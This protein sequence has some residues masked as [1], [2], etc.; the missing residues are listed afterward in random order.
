MAQCHKAALH[1]RKRHGFRAKLAELGAKAIEKVRCGDYSPFMST[2]PPE[3]I[4]VDT[5]RVSCDGASA[6][7][8]GDNYR[9]AALGH[10]R[11]YL[12]IDESGLVDCGYCDRRFV[13]KGGPA[14]QDG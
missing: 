6:I 8:G 7:R 4:H 2:T 9:P 3:I 10:P 14:D 12:E 1:Q 5:K 13:L 11:I